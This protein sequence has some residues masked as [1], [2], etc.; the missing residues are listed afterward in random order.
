MLLYVDTSN[1]WYGFTND[2]NVSFDISI[3]TI[4]WLTATTQAIVKYLIILY[5]KFMTVCSVKIIHTYSEYTVI[6][7][8]SSLQSCHCGYKF[9]IQQLLWCERVQW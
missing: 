1:P 5:A 8:Y 7:H 6:L 4:C 2:K 9:L 3:R